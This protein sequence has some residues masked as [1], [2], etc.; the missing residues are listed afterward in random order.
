MKNKRKNDWLRFEERK[1]VII[2]I[3]VKQI[4]LRSFKIVLVLPSPFAVLSLLVY[5]WCVVC[6]THIRMNGTGDT[7]L[8]R[9]RDDIK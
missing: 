9:S 1:S 3:C 8:K 4:I 5:M 2:Q 7:I 6:G